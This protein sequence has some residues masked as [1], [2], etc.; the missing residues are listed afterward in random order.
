MLENVVVSIVELNTILGRFPVA[1]AL[2]VGVPLKE[3]VF[4][5]PLLSDHDV[6]FAPESL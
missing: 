2:Y 3:I 5:V 1:F 4:P 6:R